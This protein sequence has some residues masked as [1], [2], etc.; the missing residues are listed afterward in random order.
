MPT[1]IAVLGGPPPERRDAAR[2]RARLLDAALRLVDER[3]ADQVT[4]DSVAAAACVGKGTLF[5]R[6]GSRAGLMLA[7]LDH[8]EAAWQAEVIGGPPPL[9]PGAPPMERLLAFGRSRLETSLRHADLIAAASGEHGRSHAAAAFTVLHVRHLLAELGV[10]GDLPL[11]A[12]AVLA[13]LEASILV[14]QV[15]VD[16]L[17]EGR[18]LAAWSDLVRRVCRDPL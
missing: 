10:R 2:N 5:R 4:M 18:V 1:E 13:P 16:H 12:T 15:R 9:G 3:G 8:S 7:V 14:Q 11:L 6:Y 17:S